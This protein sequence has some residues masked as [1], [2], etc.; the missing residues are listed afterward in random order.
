MADVKKSIKSTKATKNAT[1]VK[2]I[3][4]LRKDLA[5]KQQDMLDSRKSHRAGEL[6]NPR[7]LTT[8][9]KEIARLLTAIRAEELKEQKESK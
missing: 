3:D 1:V 8:Q 5:A 6:V 9:R 4:E 2:S 7:V